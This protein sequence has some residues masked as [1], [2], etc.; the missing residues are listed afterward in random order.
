MK[1]SSG[2]WH[3][4]VVCA[5]LFAGCGDAKS[6]Q[7]SG[8]DG[9]EDDGVASADT[10]AA[11]ET[12]AASMSAGP[13]S[14]ADGNDEANDDFADT[15]PVFWDV[16][17]IPDAPES[18]CGGPNGK[19]GGGGG[20][21]ELTYIWI[22]NSQQ[23]TVSKI[24]T[25]TM[26]EEGR[27]QAKQSNGDPSRTSVNLNGDVAVANRNGGVAKFWANPDDCNGNNTSTGLA[28]I[29][30]WGEDDCMAWN[31]PM[32]CSSNRPVAWTRGTWS[33]ATCSYVDA[34]L[35][36]VC[37]SEVMLLNG[38][39]GE[40]EQTILV[41]GSPFVYGGAAD[42]DGNFWGLDTSQQ[43]IFRVDHEDYDLLTF[44]LP[45]MGGY[46]ITVDKEGR[47]W[48]CGGGNVARFNLDDS[49]WTSSAGGFGG[50]GGCMTDGDTTLWHSNPSGML[51]GFDIETL[52]I[53]D[54]V[55]LPEYVHGIS[56]D[57]DGN[58]WGVGFANNNAYRADPETD[59]VDSYNQLVGAYTY[60]D[61]TGFALHTAGGGGVPQN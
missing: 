50:I 51:L 38:E 47:P 61:M 4:L 56:I 35:W 60:S 55:Q 18:K 9:A 49:T 57:F 24:H 13:T 37:D 42:A 11:E 15:G 14:G 32:S 53:V 12:G 20:G 22:S 48:V 54:T 43:T 58:V 30:P 40:T 1:T 28:D 52:E 36:T 10:G 26:I 39:T 25:E 8:A 7:G 59:Q 46:G 45:P 33:E 44:A 2:A 16:G 21:V 31:H 19:G 5:G 29:K 23:Q 27:Y 34:K 3:F 6:P 41:P 17:V